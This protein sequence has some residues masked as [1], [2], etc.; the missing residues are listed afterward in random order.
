MGRH[1]SQECGLVGQ[2]GTWLKDGLD[3]HG[4]PFQPE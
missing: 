4:D 3:E 1:G 2:D